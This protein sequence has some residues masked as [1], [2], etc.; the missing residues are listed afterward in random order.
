MLWALTSLQVA[1]S[2]GQVLNVPVLDINSRFIK[3]DSRTVVLA[4]SESS[5]FLSTEIH[6]EGNVE[7]YT[8]EHTNNREL[9]SLLEGGKLHRISDS[10]NEQILCGGSFNERLWIV[11]VLERTFWYHGLDNGKWE[12]TRI[13]EFNPKMTPSLTVDNSGKPHFFVIDRVH[14]DFGELRNQLRVF[15]LDRDEWRDRSTEFKKMI[16]SSLDVYGNWNNCICWRDNDENMLLVAD[17]FSMT[18][19]AA[20]SFVAL[21]FDNYC[22]IDHVAVS[23]TMDIA[24]VYERPV[25]PQLT[26]QLFLPLTALAVF[27][28]NKNDSTHVRAQNEAIRIDQETLSNEI[29]NVHSLEWGSASEVFLVVEWKGNAHL[30]KRDTK[31]AESIAKYPLFDLAGEVEYSIELDANGDNPIVLICPRS[32]TFRTRPSM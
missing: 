5:I 31:R 2:P 30:V 18:N 3:S 25:F 26:T 12:R 20:L 17:L 6:K 13:G 28:R 10:S 29:T 22:R 15:R 11:T 16:P 1:I 24:L 9:P 19:S 4:R 8:F 23:K 7:V 32:A 27:W 21:P 14:S